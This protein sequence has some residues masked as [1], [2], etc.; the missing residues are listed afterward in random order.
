MKTVLSYLAAVIIPLLLV[1]FF[2]TNNT[3]ISRTYAKDVAVFTDS[4]KK[5]DNGLGP[6]KELK[7]DPID[8]SLAEKGHDLFDS[9]CIACHHLDNKLIG[10]PLRNIARD[11]SPLF[12]MNYLLNTTEMQKIN[13]DIKAQIKANNGV[14]MPNQNLKKEEARELLEYFRASIIKAKV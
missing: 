6:I 9:K 5:V 1:N 13:A 11:S 3:L 14:I 12:I 7:L 4:T 2:N 8:K 10:P